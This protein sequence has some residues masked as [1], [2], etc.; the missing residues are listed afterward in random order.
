MEL[1]ER[2]VIQPAED[3]STDK[4][5]EAKKLIECKT[6]KEL[7]AEDKNDHV[8]DIEAHLNDGADVEKKSTRISLKIDAKK[9]LNEIFQFRDNFTLRGFLLGL[10]FGLIPSGW[11]AF[12]DFAFAAEDHKSTIELINATDTFKYITRFPNGTKSQIYT[13]E[14]NV[15]FRRLSK[16]KTSDNQTE[17]WQ[18]ELWR[19]D[20]ATIKSVTYLIISIPAILTIARLILNMDFL[21]MLNCERTTI[22]IL[23]IGSLQI[24][25]VTSAIGGLILLLYADKKTDS[26][27]IFFSLASVST[28]TI[29]T[30]KILALFVHGCEMKKLSMK[31]T[32]AESSNES[33]IQLIF[34]A[35]ISLWSREITHTGKMSMISSIV[36]I[37]KSSAESYLTFGSRNEL[38]G[39]SLWK[40]TCLLLTISPAFILT[41]LFRVGSFALILAWNWFVGV[42]LVLPLAICVFTMPLA[43]IKHFGHKV[44]RFFSSDR[45]HLHPGKRYFEDLSH[46]HIVTSYIAELSTTS[47]WG[48]RGRENSQKLQLAVSVFL[49]I[50]YSLLLPILI[51]PSTPWVDTYP[52]YHPDPETLR[53]CGIAVLCSGCV[54]FP[55][56]ILLPQILLHHS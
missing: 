50:L 14:K 30:V 15:S 24:I 33:A 28:A 51:T 46:G 16:F 19:L 12:S 47:N 2:K 37:G 23:I 35:I 56:Q 39:I 32:W 49:L 31:A 40:H 29:I 22:N 17:T 13:N 3:K 5:E 20:E 10:L 52:T 21:K 44:K 27:P 54:A 55:L 1:E 48:R 38:E 8:V 53:A 6:V 9:L 45:E 4:N 11:D 7:A 36:M 18:E 41:A 26:S 25:G 42:A 34:V 43:F